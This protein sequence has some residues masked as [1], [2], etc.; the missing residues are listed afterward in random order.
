MRRWASLACMITT[1]TCASAVLGQP[2]DPREMKAYRNCLSGKVEAGVALLAE[3]FIQT[4]EIN[5]IYNQGRCYEQN[6]RAEQA[7]NRFREYLRVAKNLT[8]AEKAEVN[9]H[10]DDC[11]AMQAEQKPAPEPTPSQPPGPPAA[12][13]ANGQAPARPVPPVASEVVQPE[14]A[15]SHSGMSIAGAVVGG[16]GIA[17]LVAGGIFSYLVSSAK[18]EVEDNAGKKIYDSSLYS[19][20]QKY[21]MLQWVCYGTGAGLVAAGVVLYVIGAS[22][23][24]RARA[25]SLAPSIA[26]G[27]GGL[28]LRGGF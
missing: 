28:L 16:A 21:E 4:K 6:G 1:L 8:A 7:V 24:S 14:P 20:G 25:V 12:S 3:I 17:A 10:I 9:R 23:S 13:I 15:P 26:P 18:Q 11:L 27:Q 5:L 2:Q 19:R 22:G